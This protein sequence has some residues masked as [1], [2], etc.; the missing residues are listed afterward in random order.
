M[1]SLYNQNH[2]SSCGGTEL[3]MRHAS[4]LAL[5]LCSAS[6]LW[7]YSVKIVNV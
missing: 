6:P 3:R 7:I 5:T 1:V 2:V 4:S